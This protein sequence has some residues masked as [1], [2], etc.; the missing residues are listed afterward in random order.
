M[1]ATTRAEYALSQH[2]HTAIWLSKHSPSLAV[3]I[4]DIPSGKRLLGYV[5]VVARHGV[6]FT[7]L[8]RL[9]VLLSFRK[10]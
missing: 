3:D 7:H 8:M 5:V 2:Q 9:A 1:L 10:M 6:K 4:A